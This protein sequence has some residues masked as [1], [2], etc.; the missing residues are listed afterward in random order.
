MH[1]FLQAL[2]TGDAHSFLCCGAYGEQG[3][4]AHGRWRAGI[5]DGEA[6]GWS[7]AP[8]CRLAQQLDTA[9]I[10]DTFVLK[11]EQDFIYLLVGNDVPALLW[12][13]V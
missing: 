11:G 5:S 12:Q 3:I 10:I 6:A 1:L 2:L 4:A 7:W 9:F 8:A 13:T